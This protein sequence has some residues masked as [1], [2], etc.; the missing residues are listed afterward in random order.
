MFP[1]TASAKESYR[2][3]RKNSKCTCAS[4]TPY[5]LDLLTARWRNLTV[6]QGKETQHHAQHC[7]THLGKQLNRNGKKTNCTKH[8][9]THVMSTRMRTRTY[10]DF[11]RSHAYRRW[12]ILTIHFKVWVCFHIRVTSLE[13]L[14]RWN[15][16]IRILNSQYE[17]VKTV[18]REI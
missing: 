7:N 1:Y 11:A 14:F 2:T 4:K 3:I 12:T 6:G 16:D 17:V 9:S 18:R 15:K 8:T 5:T 13:T 10:N